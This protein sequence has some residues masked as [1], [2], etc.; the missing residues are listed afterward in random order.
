[1]QRQACGQRDPRED[2]LLLHGI[3]FKLEGDWW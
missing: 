3:S 1:V 2:V